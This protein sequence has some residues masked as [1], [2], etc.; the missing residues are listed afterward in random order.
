MIKWLDFPKERFGTIVIDPPWPYR[1]KSAGP[2]GKGAA[3]HY[4]VLT[5]DQIATLQPGRLGLDNCMLW[6]WT[7]NAH[8]HD[9]F[10][11]LEAWGIRYSGT[12]VTWVKTKIGLGYWLRGQTE[13]CLLGLIGKPKSVVLANGLSYTTLLYSPGGRHSKKPDA[14]YDMVTELGEGPYLDMFSREY[15][16]N[17]TSW[18]DFC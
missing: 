12:K 4:K 15:R 6:L 1:H 17:W 11:L 16:L 14:F 8:I 9:A 7:T 2:K 10:H 5:I 3:K 13:D 18:G